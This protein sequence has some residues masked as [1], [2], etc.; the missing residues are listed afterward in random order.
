[1]L[2]TFEDMFLPALEFLATK[3]EVKRWEM[4]QRLKEVFG[5]DPRFKTTPD[6]LAAKV[7]SGFGSKFELRVSWAVTYLHKAGLLEKVRPGIYRITERG[8]KVLEEKPERIDTKYLLKF[9]EFR[10]FLKAERTPQKTDEQDE[11]LPPEEQIWHAYERYKA[12][13]VQQLVEKIRTVEPQVFERIVID[14]LV[15]MGYGGNLEEAAE[16]VGGPGDEGIDGVIKQDPLGLDNVY[17]QAKRWQ[18]TVGR[19]EIQ[20]FVG[21]LQGNGANKGVFITCGNFTEDAKRYTLSLG[22]VK[23]ILIDGQKLGELMYKYG[24]GVSTHATL[25]LKKIDNDYFQE[26]E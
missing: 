1:M 13:I 19:P 24:V 23:V 6:E 5:N 17:I 8:L 10:D 4:I 26:L 14:V 21:A 25:E 18:G 20:R 9:P 22:S 2:P 15:R 11:N 12:R 16:V 3:S 7:P